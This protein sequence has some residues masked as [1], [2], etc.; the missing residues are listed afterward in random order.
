M[1]L[2]HISIILLIGIVVFVL[3]NT[4]GDIVSDFPAFVGRIVTRDI[5]YQI[6]RAA[7]HSM[8]R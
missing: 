2:P 7:T 1:R 5:I 8:G 4:H 3:V 6:A